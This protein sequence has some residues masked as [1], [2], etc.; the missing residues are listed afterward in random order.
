MVERPEFPASFDLFV[1]AGP[2]VRS[3]QSAPISARIGA[4]IY[5]LHLTSV[6][7]SE[8]IL[9][10]FIYISQDGPPLRSG[11]WGKSLISLSHSNQIYNCSK[12]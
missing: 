5:P 12:M 2:S 4:R 6:M 3:F 9:A 10:H 11:N 8:N 7:P 1:V